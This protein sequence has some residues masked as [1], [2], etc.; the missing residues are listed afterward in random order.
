V[1]QIDA[2]NSKLSRKSAQCNKLILLG[3]KKVV[4]I[5]SKEFCL[6]KTSFNNGLIEED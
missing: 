2:A 5:P 6:S 1:H 4:A 3:Y